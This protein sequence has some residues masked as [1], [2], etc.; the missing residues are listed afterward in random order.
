MN[1][2]FAIA[3]KEVLHIIR[4]PRSLILAMLIPIIFLLLFSYAIT[5]D[6]DNVKMAVVDLDKTSKS[7]E[8]I[9]SFAAAKYFQISQ[10]TEKEK[11]LEYF[12]NKGESVLGVVIPKGFGKKISKGDEI[13]IQVLIDGTESNRA[14]VVM[15]Y[16]KGIVSF[17]SSKIIMDVMNKNGLAVKK[18]K[19]FLEGTFRSF[20]NPEMKSRN[21]IIPGLIAVI[22]SIILAILTSLT[23]IREKE[24][25]TLEQLI[26]TPITSRELLFGK[27]IPYWFVGLLDMLLV[28]IVGTV[29]FNVPLKGNILFLFF[30]SGIFA[31]CGLGIGLLV[32]TIATTQQFAIQ[33]SIIL[34]ILP[35]FILSGFLFPVKS[36]PKILQIVTYA[37]PAKYFL[38][39]L[40]GGIMLKGSGI[41][42][43]FLETIILFFFGAILIS[44]ASLKFKK[45]LL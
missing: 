26:V 15:G 41:Y 14:N 11:E 37:V 1:R 4:D 34:S 43:L 13:K 22:M 6:I 24:K 28:V 38:I 27:I 39:I 40:R 44:L 12:L 21:F 3:K 2:I 9:Q 45:K 18:D 33:L 5:L 20:Y 36:M 35:S 30:S 42:I 7:R 16:V 8:F 25:G 10:I 17:Y 32:S 29:I 19:G 31:F 23:I